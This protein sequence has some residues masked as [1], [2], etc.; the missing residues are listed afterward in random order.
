[1][2]KRFK[3][4]EFLSYLIL[5]N[6][7]LFVPS[8]IFA[9]AGFWVSILIILGVVL[10]VADIVI[11]LI[12]CL[13]KGKNYSQLREEELINIAK[14]RC[15]EEMEFLDSCI[16]KNLSTTAKILRKDLKREMSFDVI[17][18]RFFEVCNVMKTE[19]DLFRYDIKDVYEEQELVTISLIFQYQTINY[20]KELYVDISY[21][22]IFDGTEYHKVSFK[23]EIEFKV[24][25]NEEI[26]I[27][28]IREKNVDCVKIKVF[29]DVL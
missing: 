29:E 16:E 8:L 28:Q 2:K 24:F 14:K 13:S 10:F 18:T 11:S 23:D 12:A 17:L 19:G 20:T 22:N 15:E 4:S 3:V 1:M 26:I 27:K 25:L 6:Y 7:F 9:I 5:K 21:P